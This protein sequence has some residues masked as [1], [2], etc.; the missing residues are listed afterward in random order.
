MFLVCDGGGTKTDFITFSSSGR[1]Y[2]ESRK[3]GSNA[4]FLD[5]DKASDSVIEGIEECLEK[6]K[7]NIEQIEYIGR[8]IP[9]FSAS[10]EKVRK[11]F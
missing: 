8:F 9:G 6:A 3:E 2:A 11:H 1:V 7:L 10:I 4:I 5:S